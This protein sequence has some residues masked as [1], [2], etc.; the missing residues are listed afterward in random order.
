MADQTFPQALSLV[1]A[2]EGGFVNH[3][4]DP[5]GPTNKGVTQAVY[6]AYRRNKGLPT[7]SVQFIEDDELT[8][9][10][11]NQ[12]WNM[13][14][15][16]RLPAGLDYAVFDYAV[17]SGAERAVKDLQRVIGAPV[18]GQV[19]ETT[20]RLA[21]LN[22]IQDAITQLCEK[23]MAFLK[24]L[25]TWKVFGSGWQ[26]RVEGSTYGAQDI[27]T[28]VIDYAIK[29]SRQAVPS[30]PAT[31]L[32]AAIGDRAGEVAGKGMPADVAVTKTPQGKGIIA[33]AAG[34]AGTAIA[35]GGSIV[36]QVTKASAVAQHAGTAASTA[37]QSAVQIHDAAHKIFG[38]FDPSLLMLLLGGSTAL[39]FAGVA[40]FGW[41]YIQSQREKGT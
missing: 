7:R 31:A 3:P 23:R 36:D 33:T 29:I 40:F 8:E 26:R 20:I 6:D 22:N 34:T 12:Y 18:D 16:D 38:I 39:S 19:G 37:A 27:D 35:A 9:I 4:A 13:V 10:Y 24:S 11:K 2:H 21:C 1:L 30:I 5:G 15:A 25:K 41:H 32:P 17:N 28:G 14:S